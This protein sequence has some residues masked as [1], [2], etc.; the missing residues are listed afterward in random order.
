MLT[1]IRSLLHEHPKVDPN[2]ARVRLIGFGESSLD[3]EIYCLILTGVP[4]EFFAIREELLL[5]IMD[6][7]SSSGTALAL[8]SRALYMNQEQGLNQRWLPVECT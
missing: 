7:V 6:L 1:K 5:R 3:V 8:P 4:N 2:V